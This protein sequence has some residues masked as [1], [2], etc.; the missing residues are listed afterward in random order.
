MIRATLVSAVDQALLSALNFAIAAV[1]IFMVSKEDYG[2]YAQ[3]INL[4]ALFSPFHAGIFVSAYLAIGTRK[5]ANHYM[6]YQTDM[7][8][9]EVP[10][11]FISSLLVTVA[12][13]VGLR[14]A[15][16]SIDWTIAAA[17]AMTLLGL[18]WREFARQ[19][20]FVHGNYFGVLRIDLVYIGFVVIGFAVLATFKHLSTEWAFWCLGAAGAFAAGSTLITALRQQTS[21]KNIQRAVGES[22][23]IGKWDAM[24]SFATWGYAQSY[25]Y[26][27][28]M[29]GGLGLVAEVAAARLL[30]TP[31]PLLWASYA[32]VLRPTASRLLTNGDV[33]AV[34]QLSVKAA[35]FSLLIAASYA[36]FLWMALPLIEPLLASK[37]FVHLKEL[38]LIWVLYF[39]AAGITTVAASMLRSALAFRSVFLWQTLCCVVAIAVF[40]AS[41]RFA[42]QT[43]LIVALIVVELFSA[44]LLWRQLLTSLD[45]LKPGNQAL[46]ADGLPHQA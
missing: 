14:A 1:L 2:L 10:F 22:W 37:G 19:H 8:W 32:N 4:Q 13:V 31:L 40:T 27:A 12:T 17:S 29:Q 23:R 6:R 46:D 15:G 28:A 45:N 34:K 30:A 11:T 5:D 36:V 21:V 18:W 7:T 25:L 26:L 42:S 44:G 43:S 35:L 20:Q 39:A 38:A 41:F 3:L 9:A 33:T 16:T 24:G